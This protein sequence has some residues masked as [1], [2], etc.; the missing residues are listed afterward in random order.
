MKNIKRQIIRNY[1]GEI[2]FI[3]EFNKDG[4]MIKFIDNNGNDS[5]QLPII[6]DK[7]NTDLLE[8]DYFH[9]YNGTEIIECGFIKDPNIDLPV[10]D[11]IYEDFKLFLE[12][13][14]FNEFDFG[15]IEEPIHEFLNKKIT[16]KEKQELRIYVTGNE[17]VHMIVELCMWLV[18][19]K[20]LSSFM[21]FDPKNRT[22]VYHDTFT[23]DTYKKK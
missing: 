22:Y 9:E 14:C 2:I 13:E 20:I 1:N 19:H 23:S 15:E 5:R 8:Y 12:Q 21:F 3:K 17:P 10:T 11:Y 16:N 6:A 4:N 7:I 18:E